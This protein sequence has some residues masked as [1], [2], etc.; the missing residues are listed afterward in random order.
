MDSV[1]TCVQLCTTLNDKDCTSFTSSSATIDKQYAAVETRWSWR[2]KQVGNFFCL[3]AK[4]WSTRAEV[5]ECT[6]QRS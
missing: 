4:R 3:S 5:G 2:A 1:W 6:D